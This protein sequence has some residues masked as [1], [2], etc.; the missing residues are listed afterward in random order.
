MKKYNQLCR[1]PKVS[2][3]SV[4]TSICACA[5]THRDCKNW[6]QTRISVKKLSPLI[7]FFFFFLKSFTFHVGWLIDNYYDWL[8][9]RQFVVV[10]NQFQ[11]FFSIILPTVMINLF[12]FSC[13]KLWR[14]GPE[15]S[16]AMKLYSTKIGEVP[17][18][19]TL[20][21]ILDEWVH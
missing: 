5:M 14:I 4:D 9:L 8:I 18:T 2:A 10:W 1:V 7:G 19:E 3:N 11:Y 15:I 13:H 16:Y 17:Y 20:H 12:F 6:C 21:H